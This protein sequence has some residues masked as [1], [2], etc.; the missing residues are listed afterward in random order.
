MLTGKVA[1]VTGAGKGIGCQIAK[2]LASY[3]ATVV[4]NYAH[5][6]EAAEET[7]K[8][9]CENGG[10]ASVYGCNVSDFNAVAQMMKA[11]AK[12]QGSIDILVNNAGIT[13]DNLTMVM[14]E[15]EFDAVINTNLKGAFNC[16]RHVTRQMLRQKGGHIINISSIVGLVGNA[17][18]INYSASKAGVIAMTKSLAKELGGKGITVNAVA[19]GF[20]DTDMTRV[21]KEEVREKLKA[22]IPLNRLGSTQDI[23]ETVAFLASDKASYITGQTISVDGGMYA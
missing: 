8:E 4:L 14:K 9:I 21:L 11:V 1:L 23:A 2:T 19:P 20:I 18:Q 12:E 5:S 16:M 17:G 6:K 7:A 22:Q 15:E 10:K 3:G 13:K